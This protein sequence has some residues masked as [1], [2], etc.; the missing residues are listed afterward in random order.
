MTW[1]SPVV[2]DSVAPSLGVLSTLRHAGKG[3][4]F[5]S[6]HLETEGRINSGTWNL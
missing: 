3:G 5:L 4:G 1:S 6:S 2:R